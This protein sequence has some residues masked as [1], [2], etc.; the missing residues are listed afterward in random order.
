[1]LKTLNTKPAEPRKGIVGVGDDGRNRAEP[2]SKHEVDVGRND[3]N[4]KSSKSRKTLKAWKILRVIGLEE[5]LPKHQSSI[6]ELEL[7]LEL[8]HFLELFLL[9]LEAF[10]ISRLE[11]LLW[12]QS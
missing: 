4:K 1:M 6:K 7:P 3:A 10:L 8:W 5:R 9:D 2:V 11:Q 12:R